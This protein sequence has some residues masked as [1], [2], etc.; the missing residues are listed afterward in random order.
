MST[1]LYEYTH[2]HHTL[3]STSRRLSR[4][5]LEIHKIDHQKCIAV[6]GNVT[7]SKRIINHK[8]AKLIPNLGFEPGVSIPP[9]G[10]KTS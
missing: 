3:M 10:T 8:Y 1:H 6:N 2:T 5:D 9:Q 7:T 4:F